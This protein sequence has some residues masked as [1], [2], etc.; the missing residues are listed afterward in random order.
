[1]LGRKLDGFKKV[2]KEEDEIRLKV[3]DTY[4]YWYW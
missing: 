2:L 1:L 3:K 4:Y